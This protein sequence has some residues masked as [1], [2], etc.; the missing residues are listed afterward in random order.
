M[1]SL[2]FPFFTMDKQSFW[3]IFLVLGMFIGIGL[4]VF[5]L[6]ENG[7]VCSVQIRYA[8]SDVVAHM[9]IDKPR[10]SREYTKKQ[11]QERLVPNVCLPEQFDT[12]FPQEVKNWGF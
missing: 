10:P 12:V 11:L 7:T 8:L 5:S 3:T 6:S 9:D 4:L 1:S 2:F